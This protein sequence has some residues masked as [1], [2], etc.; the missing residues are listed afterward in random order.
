MARVA[1]RKLAIQLRLKGK[2]Y[3]EIKKELGISKS[4]LS[5]W[6][7]TYP[8]TEAQLKILTDN[9]KSRKN[10]AIEKTRIVKA[11]KREKRLL[12]L[13]NKEKRIWTPLNKRELLLAGFFLYWGEGNKRINGQLALNN[14]DP[15]VLKFTL[16]WLRRGLGIPKRKIKVMLHLYKDM[17]VEKEMHF[18]SKELNVPLTQ[19]FK[20]YIKESKRSD[21]DQKGFGHGTCG[22][23]I[24]DVRMKEKVIMT[25]Q[26]IAD[27]YGSFS[28]V[29]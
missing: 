27:Y 8:L 26:A 15:K 19:F 25:I 18:W 4:T 1:D 11:K 23:I 16:A 22:F 3:S 7:K 5:D 14:T 21:I 20:P 28:M 13:Y 10:L 29:Y 6:L 2:T 12:N 24:N 17:H 9:Q